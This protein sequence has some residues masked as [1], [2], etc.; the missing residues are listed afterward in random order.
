[1]KEKEEVGRIIGGILERSSGRKVERE[2][3]RALFVTTTHCNHHSPLLH[4][5]YPRSQE[6]KWQQFDRVL[7]TATVC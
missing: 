6:T 1:M 5:P 2:G 4:G 7:S 3:G